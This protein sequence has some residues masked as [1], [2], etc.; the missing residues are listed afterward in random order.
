MR[1]LITYE[2]FELNASPYR[3]EWVEKRSDKWVAR[4][5][6]D[7]DTYLVNFWPKPFLKVW[8]TE[9]E[10][11]RLGI[12]NQDHKGPANAMRVMKTVFDVIQNFIDSN[13]DV[14]VEFIGS[15]DD[16]GDPGKPSKRDK[17]YQAMLRDVPNEYTAKVG[18]DGMTV[19]VAKAGV[20][21]D[22]Q[23]VDEAVKPIVSFDFDGVLHRSVVDIH[24]ISWDKPEEWTPF[25]EMFAV[26]HEEAKAN[27]IVVVTAR[28]GCDM[29]HVWEFIKMHKLPVEKV[30]CTDNG[31]KIPVL[32]NIDA[33]RHYDDNK[34]IENELKGSGI[35]FVKVDPVKGEYK[36]MESYQQ[37]GLGSILLI[38]AIDLED[39]THRLYANYIK[40]V[41]SYDRY[42]KDDTKGQAA[43][44]VLL[45]DDFFRIVRENG[46][47]KTQK[48]GESK[49]GAL[50]KA[51]G[52]Q[53]NR[54]VLNDQKT[55]KHWE[56]LKYTYMPKML[57][58]LESLLLSLPDVRWNN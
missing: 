24:P 53:S 33:I 5:V 28:D 45:G 14:V 21:L 52:L 31:P 8:K 30:Y 55:P 15:A 50:L 7:D 19:R 16:D 41:L 40:K 46:Q 29:E 38:N 58:E 49:P 47:F 9:F 17:V 11:D 32:R 25:E 12:A 39:G 51:L 56:T 13:T 35:E 26:M 37:A 22:Q 6:T 1:H 34:K 36:L 54:V 27:R 2:L 20:E 3:W 10:S 43:K 48:V 23:P 18:A 44:M 57:K 42:K 4:F